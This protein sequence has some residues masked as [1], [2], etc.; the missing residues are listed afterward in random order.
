MPQAVVYY[1]ALDCLTSASE[2]CS[3]V[4]YESSQSGR[5][6]AKMRS[7][8]SVLVVFILAF[9]PLSSAFE[10]SAI[11]RDYRNHK[12]EPC[13]LHELWNNYIHVTACNGYLRLSMRNHTVQSLN[14]EIDRLLNIGLKKSR[15]ERCPLYSVFSYNATHLIWLRYPDKR[16]KDKHGYSSE[17]SY[18]V[19]NV[20]GKE[21]KF[22]EFPSRW[23]D[24]A[25]LGHGYDAED[26]NKMT[27]AQREANKSICEPGTLFY[28]FIP[29]KKEHFFKRVGGHELKVIDGVSRDAGNDSL[30]PTNS[31]R[32]Y[33]DPI[34]PEVYDVDLGVRIRQLSEGEVRYFT[35]VYDGA[36]VL[37]VRT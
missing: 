10:L 7:L 9:L 5:S 37:N 19:E 2:V 31:L 17:V 29:S 27:P 20:V 24:W 6:S 16:Q 33:R 28:D 32:F 35:Q 3:F 18:H 30:C 4:L 36:A 14:A 22:Q 8:L 12:H 13:D 23:E 15:N 34:R 26:F 11:V 25:F 1:L 21:G